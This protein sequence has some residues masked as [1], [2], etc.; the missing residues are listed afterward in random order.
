MNNPIKFGGLV[1][2]NSHR[3]GKFAPTSFPSTWLFAFLFI[4]P[5]ANIHAE[6]PSEY[7]VKTAF[8]HNIARFVEW[9][10]A[11]RAGGELRL[12]LLGQSPLTEAAAA[13]AGE[14]IDG[15]KWEVRHVNAR[16]A[17]RECQV[18]LIAASESDNLERILESIKGSAVLT[19]GDS[20]GYAERGVMVGFYLGANKVRFEINWE[21]ARRAGIKINSQLLKLARI[22]QGNGGMQ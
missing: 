16:S 12:C 4:L 10:A 8:V 21:S 18:L 2:A 1:G 20:G 7:E 9:S 15:L 14:K 19:V 5:C 13:L 17:L 3:S 11:S 6:P 22:V